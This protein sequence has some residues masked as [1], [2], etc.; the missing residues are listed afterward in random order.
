MTLEDIK[1][2]DK[3]CIKTFTDSNRSNNFEV[4]SITYKSP[5]I[6]SGW[7]EL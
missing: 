5:E 4:T 1:E 7:S 6:L 2:G 3:I